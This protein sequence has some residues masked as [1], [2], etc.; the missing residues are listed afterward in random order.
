MENIGRLVRRITERRRQGPLCDRLQGLGKS[1]HRGEF[2]GNRIRQGRGIQ[3]RL[4]P[5]GLIETE[6]FPAFGLQPGVAP[7]DPAELRVD[8][9]GLRRL[10][11]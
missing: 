4:S 2:S 9:T 6:L 7:L 1:E 11:F 8:A 5:P 10:G 3:G